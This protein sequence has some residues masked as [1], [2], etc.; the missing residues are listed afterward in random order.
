MAQAPRR[1]TKPVA[2]SAETPLVKTP[3][4]VACPLLT[5]PDAKLAQD[6]GALLGL[7]R[8]MW[9]TGDWEGL[10][11]LDVPYLEQHPDRAKVC[12]L[13]G[14]AWLQQGK[15]QQARM[16]LELALKWGCDKALVAQQLVS[17]VHNS[18]GRAAA[19]SGQGTK[20]LQHFRKA[21]Q[22]S[23]KTG[24]G[25][26]HQRWHAELQSMGLAGGTAAPLLTSNKR[27]VVPASAD[28]IDANFYRA[29][30]DRFRGSRELI[31]DRVRVYLP[32][33]EPVARRHP[34]LRALDLGCGRG[35]WL[36]VM[37][38]AGINGHGVDQDA[39]MLSAC[40]ELE[41]VVQRGDAL[42]S[43]RRQPAASSICI[44]LIHVV[45]H[46]PFEVVKQIV[47]EARRVLVDD[48]ILIME[49]PNPENYTVGACNFYQDPTH[50]NPL[51]PL[52]LAFV[53]EYY[54]YERVKVLRLQEPERLAQKDS[55]D[56]YDFLT[57]IS[58][59]YSIIS[60]CKKVAN[61]NNLLYEEDECWNK[62]YG[63]D[64]TF[65]VSK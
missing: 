33:V 4:L 35:E 41:L 18:L 63:V 7:V 12:L 37:R 11:R 48:G 60:Q 46:L 61:N 40:T 58:P 22:G 9:L 30:E 13:L 47:K 36:E 39:G 6:D 14:S 65:M 32:F 31:K 23:G 57:G 27:S 17:G 56:I 21:V 24:E 43:L 19:A 34:H 52:L 45:E 53:P 10:S 38:E 25:V 16:F 26:T 8:Q 59:D 50:R 3:V 54:G 15:A 51:P 55:Y 42:E 62:N 1:K 29:F 44:S 5:N 49:T 2:S 20:Q 64:M 28:E